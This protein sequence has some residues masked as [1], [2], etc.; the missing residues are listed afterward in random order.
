MGLARTTCVDADERVPLGNLSD[1][2]PGASTELYNVEARA[3]QLLQE[4]AEA[5]KAATRGVGS[6][7]RRLQDLIEDL[8]SQTAQSVWQ[9]ANHTLRRLTPLR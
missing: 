3:D 1:F 9:Q 2:A 4:L 6:A 7:V 5:S 8:P